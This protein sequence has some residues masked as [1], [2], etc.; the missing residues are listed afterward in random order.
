MVRTATDRVRLAPADWGGLFSLAITVMA[1]LV[2]TLYQVHNLA[3]TSS[4]RMV[5]LEPEVANLK[6]EV[7]LL[8]SDI[9]MLAK[10]SG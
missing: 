3:V 10:R 7:S 6:S 9:R 4:E 5:R 1:L 2:T 8:Q